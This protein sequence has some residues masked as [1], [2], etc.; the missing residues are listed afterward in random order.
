MGSNDFYIGYGAKNNK[1][2]TLDTGHFHPTESVADKVSSLL[3]YVNQYNLKRI[4]VFILFISVLIS[5]SP[6]SLCTAYI[7]Y[8]IVL[9]TEK[10][11]LF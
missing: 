6:S 4:S 9:F 5:F 3:L 8:D 7:R 1:M 10:Q 2:I 11:A